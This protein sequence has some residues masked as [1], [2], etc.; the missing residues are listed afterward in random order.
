MRSGKSRVE[1][2]LLGA[3]AGRGASGLRFAPMHPFLLPFF[4]GRAEDGGGV[5]HAR[6]P[7]SNAK[8]GLHD[9]AAAR[10]S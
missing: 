8:T 1:A 5:P 9:Q 7:T 2:A 4:C 6:L 3:R 10:R